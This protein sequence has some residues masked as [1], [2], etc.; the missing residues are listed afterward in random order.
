MQAANS[1]LQQRLAEAATATPGARE[2]SGSLELQG[3]LESTEARCRE[4]E[5]V[6]RQSQHRVLVLA[7]LLYS[8]VGLLPGACTA[9]HACVQVCIHP[10]VQ[11]HTI[12][13]SFEDTRVFCFVEPEGTC[14]MLSAGYTCML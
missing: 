14:S 1:S 11:W 3:R 9:V 8:T 7:F 6:S 4:L 13:V 2:P 5:H 12:V 10:F